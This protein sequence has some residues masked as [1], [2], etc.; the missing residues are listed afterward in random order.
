MLDS[1]SAVA[2]AI[3]VSRA[4]SGNR[5]LALLLGAS[6]QVPL[7]EVGPGSRCWTSTGN[8]AGSG[9]GGS[10]SSGSSS[11]SSSSSGGAIDSGVAEV[12]DCRTTPGL[13]TL[14]AQDN[15]DYRTAPVVPDGTSVYW[16]TATVS[17]VGLPAVMKV[18]VC[19]GTPTTVAAGSTGPG[20]IRA[21][22]ANASSAF[23]IEG[24]DTG[25]SL[26]VRSA[27][28]SGGI[29]ATMIAS[30]IG[31]WNGMAFNASDLC[32]ADYNQVL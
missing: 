18:P 12:S 3:L 24:P 32:F 25:P 26:A 5:V 20:A 27:P 7:A 28:L 22:T 31:G 30:V 14:A 1:L 16:G 21:L 6:A 23:W 29:A 17:G 13:V 9:S 8:D 4:L 10:G 15:I 11:G 2:H 19:G